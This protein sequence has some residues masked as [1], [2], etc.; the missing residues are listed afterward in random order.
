MNTAQHFDIAIC[1]GGMVGMSLGLA[2]AQTGMKAALIEKTAMPAQLEPSFDG[3]VSAIAEG[4]RRI[5]DRIG[6]WKA[7]ASRA[8][9]ILDI[10]VSDGN[11]PFFLHY[12]H[13]EIGDAPFGHIVENRYIRHALHSAAQSLPNL[14]IID[15]AILQSFERDDAGVTLQLKDKSPTYVAAC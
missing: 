8:E 15:N 9:P 5:L 10:R 2:L 14:T 13:K 4:S 11:A 3:R 1:G 7:M 6:A 12:D